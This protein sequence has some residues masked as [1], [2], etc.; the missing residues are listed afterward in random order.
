MKDLI[1]LYPN[2][3]KQL[4]IKVFKSNGT[5]L[6]GDWHGSDMGQGYTPPFFAAQLNSAQDSFGDIIQLWNNNGKQ[7]MLTYRSTGSSF[8]FYWGT[9]NTLMGYTLPVFPGDIN[10]DGDTDLLQLW[11]GGGLFLMTHIAD[12]LGKLSWKWGANMHQGF[13]P[14]FIPL[15]I[16]G[17]L[18]MDLLQLWNMNGKTGAVLHRSKGSYYDFEW[19]TDNVGVPYSGTYTTGDANADGL[20][21]LIQIYKVGKNAALNLFKATFSADHWKVNFTWGSSDMGIPYQGH[22]LPMRLNTQGRADVIQLYDELNG[23]LLK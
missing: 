6:V 11:N 3:S 18:K 1:Y 7:G 4:A 16:D 21:D 5:D 13:T 14:P 17:D 23:F 10:G 15:D 8:Q 9:S 22:F 12:G 20:S 2:E 19:G